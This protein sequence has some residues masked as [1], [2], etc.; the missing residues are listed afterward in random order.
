M[1]KKSRDIIPFEERDRVI[2]IEDSGAGVCSIRIAGFACIGIGG[3][4]IEQSG[5][6][7][8][9]WRTTSALPRL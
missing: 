5:T 6:R 3:G 1:K 8:L 2:G 4:N 7:G 9:F